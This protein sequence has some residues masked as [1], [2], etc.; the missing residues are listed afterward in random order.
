VTVAIGLVCSDGV[1]VAS[2]SMSSG[3]ARFGVAATVQKVYAMKHVPVVWTGSG[4]VYVMEEVEKS[5]SELD[6]LLSEPSSAVAL[7]TF[8]TPDTEAIRTTLSQDVRKTMLACY[9]EALPRGLEQTDP[10]LG[11][12]HPF[13]TDF[14]FLGNANNTPW[15]L[16]IAAGGGVEWHT[17]QR[18]FALGSGGDAASAA[19][20]VLHHYVGDDLPTKLGVGFAFRLVQATCE[21]STG[22]VRPPVQLAI[23]DTEGAKVLTEI[24]EEDQAMVSFVQ[25]WKESERDT[26]R[27]FGVQPPE[28]E[29]PKFADPSN[30]ASSES[31]P[32]SS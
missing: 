27:K 15:L 31:A 5:I 28:E 17:S 7:Q 32:P 13:M 3:G 8:Q 6:T 24:G 21:V 14:I 18:F 9:K 10:R 12:I 1:V 20:V 16:E 23:A 26:L 19:E 29:P 11:G 22:G 2:D 25:Q 4:H 30:G